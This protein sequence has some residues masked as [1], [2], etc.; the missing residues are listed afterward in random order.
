V[1]IKFLYYYIN[2]VLHEDYHLALKTLNLI[3]W[4]PAHCPLRSFM[5]T[6]KQDQITSSFSRL[7]LYNSSLF[8]PW[9]AG[10]NFIAET[11]EMRKRLL[12]F[13]LA[14]QKRKTKRIFKI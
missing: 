3:S 11:S 2:F 6:C 7:T 8:N 1:G 4:W 10:N 12:T 13:S 5:Y 14:K 9:L